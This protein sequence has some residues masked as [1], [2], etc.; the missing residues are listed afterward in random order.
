MKLYE[1]NVRVF[2]ASPYSGCNEYTAVNGTI[3]L[4]DEQVRQLVAIVR[5]NG[6]ETNA[7]K[8]GLQEKHPSVY[9]FLDRAFRKAA[10]E[11]SH[12]HWLI[13]SFKNGFLIEPDDLME[14]L[15]DAGLFRYEPNISGI[16]ENNG[17]TK[18]DTFRAW[19]GTYFDSLDED[20]RAEFIETYYEGVD[21]EPGGYDY[22]IEIPQEIAKIALAEGARQQ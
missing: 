6:G 18:G 16:N 10:S 9:S 7:E 15:K 20:E 17:D 14:T 4:D 5:E 3:Y 19:L 1:F 12:R 13:Y 22:I 8:L 11:A 21:G 2:L